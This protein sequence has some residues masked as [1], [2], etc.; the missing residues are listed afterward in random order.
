[1]KYE[2]YVALVEEFGIAF[3][4]SYCLLHG[5]ST[6]VSPNGRKTTL[7]RWMR[8]LSARHLIPTFVFSDK[9]F[10]QVNSV[11]KV[12]ICA[13]VFSAINTYS[14]FIFSVTGLASS[15]GAA[16]SVAFKKVAS[17]KIETTE[18]GHFSHQY[19]TE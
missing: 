8:E 2:L 1:L 16:L 4:I 19:Y 11:K 18:C 14:N 10:A 5:G 15:K 9:D 7:T 13:I 3:P 12:R 6:G 17:K